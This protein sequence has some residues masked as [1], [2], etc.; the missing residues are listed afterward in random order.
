MWLV[1]YPLFFSS[2]RL[3]DF[4]SNNA[5]TLADLMDPSLARDA[6][7]EHRREGKRLRLLSFLISLIYWKRQLAQLP[8][9]A[10]PNGRNP[11][12]T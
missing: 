6:V 3:L 11:T 7:D 5:D 8:A 9:L 2:P 12:Y 1:N 4:I 10:L